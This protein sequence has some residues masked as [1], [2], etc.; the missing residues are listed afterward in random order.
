MTIPGS[1]GEVTRPDVLLNDVDQISAQAEATHEPLG[2]EAS[3][4]G[5][6]ALGHT[7]ELD[8]ASAE[9]ALSAP[10][11]RAVGGGYIDVG[12]QRLRMPR[13]VNPSPLPPT[14]YPDSH[15]YR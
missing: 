7:V 13:P 10:A 12:G 6:M 1:A 15:L 8:A 3:A 14:G 2:I 5:S 11:I 9:R 4:V